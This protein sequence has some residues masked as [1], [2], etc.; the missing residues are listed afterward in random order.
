ML[1][2]DNVA[3]H[4]QLIRGIFQNAII[5]TVHP[6]AVETPV[7]PDPFDPP[8]RADKKKKKKAQ[9]PGP[10][11]GPTGA[12]TPPLRPPSPTLSPTD[13]VPAGPRTRHLARKLGVLDAHN[14]REPHTPTP[15]PFFAC[16]ILLPRSGGLG[17]RRDRVRVKVQPAFS[18][19]VVTGREPGKAALSKREQQDRLSHDIIW[20]REQVHERTPP[21]VSPMQTMPTQLPHFSAGA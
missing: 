20:L 13:P 12:P 15:A 1:G 6:P 4:N 7:A 9:P 11:V 17:G 21:R 14:T 5:N 3:L 10:N 16:I 18:R 19:T 2:N 8:V